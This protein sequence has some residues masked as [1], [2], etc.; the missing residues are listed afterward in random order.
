MN[1]KQDIL[2]NGLPGISHERGYI[3]FSPYSRKVAWIPSNRLN[4]VGSLQG[5][6]NNLFFGRPSQQVLQSETAR[7]SLIITSDCN[8]RCKY[9]YAEAGD[10]HEYMTPSLA[11]RAIKEMI[12]PNTKYLHLT[13][14]GGEPTLN[15]EVIREAIG[16]VE[17]LDLKGHYHLSTNGV[18][19][20]DKLEYLV[21]KDFTINLSMDGFP[22]V[23]DFQRPSPEEKPSSLTVERA[24]R[25]LVQMKAHFKVRATITDYNVHSM[26]DSVTYWASLGV[27]FIHFEPINIAGRAI[28]SQM[29]LPDVDTYVSNFVSAL[30]KAEKLGVGIINSAYMNLLNPS[31]HYCTT[32]AGDK[33]IFAPDGAVT[34]CYEVQSC[35]H[36]LR[37]FVVGKYNHI[38]DSFEIDASKLHKMCALSVESYDECSNCFA[39]YL[40][41]GGCPNRNFIATGSLSKVNPWICAVKK[42]LIR[43]AIIRIYEASLNNSKPFIFEHSF[44][45]QI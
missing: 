37:D 9:C 33:F 14:F 45:N 21:K 27:K 18:V 19:S 36:T 32:V 28:S 34:L 43:N 41:S 8:L 23:H 22:S 11:I 12:K 44:V 1:L 26:A 40:C 2:L 16:F 5:V 3:V 15:M 35:G 13:F 6:D 29:S 30:D 20:N 7:V 24:I 25:K 38:T 4:E 42:Q 10:N 17:T 39:K 31:I